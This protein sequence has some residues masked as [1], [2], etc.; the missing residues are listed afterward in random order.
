MTSGVSRWIAG[1]VVAS[2]LLG[3]S[4]WQRQRAR[5]IAECTASGGAWEGT[6]SKCIPLPS[7]GPL[8][9]RDLRRS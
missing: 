6:R 2:V 9:Q 5:L 8:L 7:G 3:L 4:Q 1:L